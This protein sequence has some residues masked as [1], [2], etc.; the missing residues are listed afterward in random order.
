MMDHIFKSFFVSL[1]DLLFL[2]SSLFS[3]WSFF[4]GV[5]FRH[6]SD[7][8]LEELLEINVFLSRFNI[9]T[10]NGLA[11]FSTFTIE[12]WHVVKINCCSIWD[13]NWFDFIVNISE[14]LIITDSIARSLEVTFFIE[15]DT[16]INMWINITIVILVITWNLWIICPSS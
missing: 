10:I 11:D 8:F 9:Q 1:C 16:F 4:H 14:R 5:F 7:A 15:H 6:D 3:S 2:V 12:T 13:S